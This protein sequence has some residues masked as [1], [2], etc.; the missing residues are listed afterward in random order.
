MAIAP[1]GLNGVGSH[2]SQAAELE[3]SR[4]ERLFGAF[5]QVSHDISLSLAT[6]TGAGSAQFLQGDV[7]FAAI[8]PF[9]GQ[10]FTDSLNVDG[11][12]E[13]DLLY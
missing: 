10:F 1:D 11:A 13:G 3:G 12:H 4:A 8:I 7:T 5:V 6:R 2:K 9:Y